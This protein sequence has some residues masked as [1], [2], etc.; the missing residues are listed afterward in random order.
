[1]VKRMAP[2]RVISFV[3]LAACGGLC[4]SKRPSVDL[5]QA[6]NLNSSEVQRQ[7]M[8]TW[9]SLPDA[10][11]VL[12]RT[13]PDRFQTFLVEARSPLTRGTV[14]INASLMRE[15][16]LGHV[17]PRLQ[18]N[19]AT[20]DKRVSTGKEGSGFLERYLYP[21]LLKPNLR[22]HPSTSSSFVG[23]ATDAASRMFVARDDSGKGR[24]NCSYFL[25]VLTSV[26]IH[27]AYRPYWARSTSA[28]F[29]NFGSTIG[30]D[31]GISL[32]HEFG[33][34][35]R[36]M[37]KGHPLKGG[38]G[39]GERLTQDQKP[40]GVVFH[41]GQRMSRRSAHFTPDGE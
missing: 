23:R 40:R 16:E 34:G 22:Y 15:T 39:T 41:P 14:G 25:G 3:L 36:Q 10:P 19:F 24:L 26:A 30:S 28:T 5:L 12:L 29:N 11:S 31:A 37:V 13:H 38:S 4:Q 7:E 18:P 6:D 27:T 9:R 21:S 20:S 8:R 1:M 32:F 33:P 17:T 35:I 2:I